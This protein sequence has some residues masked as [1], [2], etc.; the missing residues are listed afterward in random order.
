M[1]QLTPAPSFPT[2]ET[3]AYQVLREAI[4]KGKFSPGER[5][6]MDRLSKEMGISPI[7]LRAA[8]QRL[9][10]EGLVEI[11]PHSGAIVAPVS[12][13]EIGDIFLLLEALEAPAFRAA[14]R[15][16]TAEDLAILQSMVDEMGIAAESGDVEAWGNTNELFH[17]TVAS[18]S[19]MRLLTE[20]TGRALDQWARLRRSFAP[21]LAGRMAQAQDDHRRMMSLLLQGDGES[22]AEL[23]AAHNRRARIAY[24]DRHKTAE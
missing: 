2:K 3:Y 16:V 19:G 7:P 10:S 21:V 12:Q 20:M 5:L 8:L 6:V 18:L 22:L 15:R 14:A 13:A 9:E 17:R 11:T 4:L 23:A 1:T 24:E